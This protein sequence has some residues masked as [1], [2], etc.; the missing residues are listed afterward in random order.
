MTWHVLTGEYPPD[1]GGVGD[2]TAALAHALADAGD[3]VHVW[4]PTAGGLDPAPRV[5]LHPLPDV[6]GGASRDALDRAFAATPG[7]VLLQYVPN[8]FGANGA[9]LA[10]CRWF[11][12]LC[13][14][15]PDVRVMF[16][17]PYFYFTWS[18]PWKRSNA[19][20]VVQRLMARRLLRGASRVYFSTETW[21]RYLH[22]SRPAQALPIPS[23]LPAAA[24][25]AA[26]ARLRETATHGE[27]GVILVGHF[28]TYGAH[29]AGELDAVLPA[30]VARLP[31]IRLALVGS[32]GAAYLA[33]LADRAPGVA[34]RA[35]APDR[36]DAA[37]VAAALGACDV[38]VQP[39]PDGI[40][41]RRTSVMAG[42]KIGVATVS[43]SG[44]LTELLWRETEAVA[45]APAGDARG[46]VDRVE[47]LLA[48]APARA[49][50]AAR[51]A[52][53]YAARFSMA[54]TIA[55]LRDA[56]AS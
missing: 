29:V 26:I 10:F 23:S 36:L 21:S 16:H 51:A 8:A 22:G 1:C 41:T 34:Q 46:I 25:A 14:R 49:A 55:I 18:K 37:G 7:I 33:R 2:Y 39:Y 15:V 43:T 35:W 42:L 53:T 6:F 4:T 47:R 30:L 24:G 9:N 32:G 40:T 50:L 11:S 38:L 20:A 48:D 52:A 54:H 17:E 12:R 27:P 31:S 45:L 44:A 19:L 13:P 56:P 28:G 3:T 5:H